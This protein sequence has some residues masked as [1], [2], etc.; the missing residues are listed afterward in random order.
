MT[1]LRPVPTL[2]LTPAS[3]ISN[4]QSEKYSVSSGH[5]QGMTWIRIYRQLRAHSQHFTYNC[6][7]RLRMSSHTASHPRHTYPIPLS[8]C[9]VPGI[10]TTT[11]TLSLFL[12]AMHGWS[13]PPGRSLSLLHSGSL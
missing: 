5:R 12:S 8:P 7:V 10:R 13:D 6:Q 4:M 11:P 3:T 1:I 9:C 2:Q